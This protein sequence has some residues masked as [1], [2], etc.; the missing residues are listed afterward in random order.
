MPGTG[1]K[2]DKNS[3]LVVLSLGQSSLAAQRFRGANFTFQE[4]NKHDL[5]GAIPR[6]SSCKIFI[7]LRNNL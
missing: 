7:F 5:S 6:V 2:Y 1:L 3:V 4:V